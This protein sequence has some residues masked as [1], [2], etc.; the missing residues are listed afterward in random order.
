MLRKQ[1]GAINRHKSYGEYVI[2][3]MM[4]VQF[5]CLFADRH[6]SAKPRYLSI[7]NS[8]LLANCGSA[9]VGMIPSEFV[10]YVGL[11]ARSRL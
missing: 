11:F 4:L 10:K 9:T 3:A 6:C 8:V 5:K 7:S 2:Q 1:S